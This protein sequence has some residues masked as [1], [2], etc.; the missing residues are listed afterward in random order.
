M[1]FGFIKSHPYVTGGA[2]LVGAIVL[3]VASRG[4]GSATVAQSGPSQGQLALQ[5][6][7]LQSQTQI[8]LAGVAAQTSQKHDQLAFQVAEDTLK[9][10]ADT[11]ALDTTTALA[12]LEKNLG[13]QIDLATINAGVSSHQID[14]QSGTQ[15]ELAGISA[16]AQADT[17]AALTAVTTGQQQT[18]QARIAAQRD[19][20]IAGINVQPQIAAINANLQ[21]QILASQDQQQWL[22]MDHGLAPPG[23]TF[24]PQ[25]KDN[26]GQYV[27][28]GLEALAMFL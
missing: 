19:I 5:G 2:V 26:T 24:K 11:H 22:A 8:A 15:V 21:D 23:Y 17:V 7:A 4:S 20:S 14:V 3:F 18:E 27:E 1:D 28:A 10:G 25:A 12:A 6:A 13:A 9:A 16:K